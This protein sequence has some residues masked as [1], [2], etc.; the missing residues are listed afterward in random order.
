WNDRNGNEQYYWHGN[1]N[2]THMCSCGIAKMC[3]DPSKNCNCDAI[4]P[5][6]LVDEGEITAKESLPI[7]RLNFGRTTPAA[8][9]GI[10]TLGKLKCSG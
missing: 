10:H 1:D 6:D 3:V 9:S 7:T 2:S 5:V 4:V 8:S